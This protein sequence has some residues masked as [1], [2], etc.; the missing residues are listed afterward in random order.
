MNK[1]DNAKKLGLHPLV[2]ITDLVNIYI[3]IA[4]YDGIC[5]EICEDD[6][7][8]TDDLL[9]DLGTT[10]KKHHLVSDD[11]LKLMENLI[12]KLIELQNNK[13]E[14]EKLLKDLPDEF[15]CGLTCDMMKDPVQLPNSGSVVDRKSIKQHIMLNGNTDP[16]SRQPL[17]LEDVIEMTDLKKKI[18]QWYNQKISQLNLPKR[19]KV[20]IGGVSEMDE[21][22][23]VFQSH[24][25][26]EE[27]MHDP[28]LPFNRFNN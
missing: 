1:I 3:N 6:R 17:K 20:K 25:D 13:E 4:D 21:E 23:G 19:Q 18:D 16:F 14:M 27:D 8:Y 7:S 28:S 26:H 22:D 15:Q 11:S 10:A 9:I 24:G 2:M 12:N 5:R